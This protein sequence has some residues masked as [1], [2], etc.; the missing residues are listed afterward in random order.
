MA[1]QVEQRLA[2]DLAQFVALDGFQRGVPG[3]KAVHIVEGRRG[4]ELRPAVPQRAIRIEVIFL[5]TGFLKSH[6]LWAWSQTG[7]LPGICSVGQLEGG[8]MIVDFLIS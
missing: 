4:V 1:L 5:F 6:V 2:L 7:A 8:C 3:L